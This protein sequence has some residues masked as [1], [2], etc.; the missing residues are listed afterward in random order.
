MSLKTRL[1]NLGNI[2]EHDAKQL[3]ILQFDSPILLNGDL[4]FIRHYSGD[5]NFVEIRCDYPDQDQENA[6]RNAI[7][8]LQIEAEDAVRG[9]A[10][11]LILTD[12]YC[13]HENIRVPMIL[14]GG[15]C[16]PIWLIANCVPLLL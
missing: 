8:R 14:A 2:L 16:I 11:Q 7:Y 3:K 13:D 6:M 5:K 12:E 9:G 1:G 15:R 4:P 10:S